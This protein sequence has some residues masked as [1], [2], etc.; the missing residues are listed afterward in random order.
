MN[1]VWENIPSKNLFA[2]LIRCGKTLNIQNISNIIYGLSEIGYS[3]NDLSDQTHQ[4]FSDFISCNI[5][6]MTTQ[7]FTHIMYSITLMSF[8]SSF[9]IPILKINS[10]TNKSI[11]E[12]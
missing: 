4:K 6:Q 5:K 9:D 2:A 3:W 12:S 11:N 7:H 1:Y 10:K 8:D